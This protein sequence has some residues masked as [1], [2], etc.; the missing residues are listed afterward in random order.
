M[1]LAPLLPVDTRHLFRPVSTALVALLRGVEPSAWARPTVAGS[2]TVRDV[3]AHM[4]DT[5][6]RRLSF[7]R[8]GMIPPAPDTPIASDRD[9]VAFINGLNAQW[10]RAAQRLSPRVLTD[11]YERA[12]SDAADWYESLPLDAPALFPVSWAGEEASA[13]WFD[14]GREFTEVWHHQEQIRMAV[15][16]DTLADP[17]YLSV[18]IDVALRGLP[19]AFRDVSAEVG[20]NVV[21]DI[22]GASGGQWTLSYNGARWTLHRGTPEATT[23]VIRLTDHTAWKVLFNALPERE[24]AAAILVEGAPQFGRAFLRARS[25]IV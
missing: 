12:A 10:I 4:L 11:V 2:W 7:H 18:V 1:S 24:A 22:T 20:Q 5:T 14:L 25:V 13:A 17:R 19:Y 8:D 9:F 21:L 6:L 23:A 16:A 15:G 3:V